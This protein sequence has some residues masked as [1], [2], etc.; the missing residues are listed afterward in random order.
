M[1]ESFGRT[2]L[3]LLLCWKPGNTNSDSNRVRLVARP[4]QRNGRR[5]LAGS[6]FTR[7]YDDSVD[8]SRCSRGAAPGEI[9]RASIRPAVKD[10]PTAAPP[11]VHRRP[12]RRRDRPPLRGDL[13]SRSHHPSA[14]SHS[15]HARPPQMHGSSGSRIPTTRRRKCPVCGPI[16]TRGAGS[17]RVDTLGHR[18][19]RQRHL[20]L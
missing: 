20:L 6:S 10:H 2:S 3:L 15:V 1:P 5:D 4:N 9:R 16:P 7:G 8:P 11:G 13:N 12:R 17:R 19:P 18:R 14:L